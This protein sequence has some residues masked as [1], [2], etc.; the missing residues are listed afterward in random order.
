MKEAVSVVDELEFLD[1]NHVRIERNAFE[2]LVVQLP[3]GTTHTK[4]EPICAFPV[5]ETNR[6]ISLMDEEGNEIGIIED[7]KQLPR[8]SCE[9]YLL[10]NCRN[11]TLCQRLPKST[12]WMDNSG[13]HSG[14]LKPL[15][16]M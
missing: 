6:Y 13:L 9:G 4:V 7:I 8:A 3:D 12:S 11:G 14:W 16:G 2:E 15:R 5:S 1:A 10:M